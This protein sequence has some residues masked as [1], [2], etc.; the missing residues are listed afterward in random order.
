M[1]ERRG[2]RKAQRGGQNPSFDSPPPKKRNNNN[3]EYI[4]RTGQ[5][6]IMISFPVFFKLKLQAKASKRQ[7][8]RRRGKIGSGERGVFRERERA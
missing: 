1:D 7:N 4:R 2:D 3:Y 8:K 5:I 6:S